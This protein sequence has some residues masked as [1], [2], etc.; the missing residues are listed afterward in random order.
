MKTIISILIL[1]NLFALQAFSQQFH[2]DVYFTPIDTEKS[3]RQE[4]KSS[5]RAERPNFRNGAREIIYIDNRNNNN[6]IVIARDTILILAEAND[7]I[8]ADS[9]SENEEG[10]YLHGFTGGA[11]EFEFAERIRRFHNPRHVIHVSD[12]QYTNIYFLNS[13]DW[14]VYVDGSY[15]WVTPTWTNPF[16]WNYYWRPHSYSSWAWRNWHMGGWGGWHGGWHMGSLGGWHAGWGGW[17]GGWFA[18]QPWAF[19]WPY[20]FGGFY[21]GFYGWG[22]PFLHHSFSYWHNPYWG[23]GGFWGGGIVGDV[24]NRRVYY[25]EHNRRGM[26]GFA[27]NS[28]ASGNR[29]AGGVSRVSSTGRSAAIASEAG[30]SNVNSVRSANAIERSEYGNVRPVSTLRNTRV[31]GTNVNVVDTRTRTVDNNVVRTNAGTII[32]RNTAQSTTR[33]EEMVSRNAIVNSRN[34]TSSGT[35]IST[36]RVGSGTAP[37]RN[38]A[39]TSSSSSSVTNNRTTTPQGASGYNQG[40]SVR[41]STPSTPNTQFNQG[42]TVRSTTP[43]QSA[44]SHSGSSVRSSS[45]SFSAPSSSGGGGGGTSRGSGGSSGG[46]SSGGRR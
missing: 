16:W 3:Q 22:H 41:R 40:T 21:D 31:T 12:P 42:N 15:A 24:S 7:S 39:V 20:H 13:N 45:P 38:N 23:G 46:V 32:T 27:A 29:I 18:H 19:G 34:T 25:S 8:M 5:T 37:V 35:P 17:H 30:R 28:A 26:S 6:S 44:P 2:D 10:Y 36:M 4:V 33:N 43:V 11:T 9:V 1:I 14:N